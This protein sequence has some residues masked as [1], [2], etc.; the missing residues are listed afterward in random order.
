MTQHD[1]L[2]ELITNPEYLRYYTPFEIRKKLE[3]CGY[4]ILPL[5][6][7]SL[8]GLPFEAGGGYKINFEDGGLFQYHPRQH[9]HH[10]DEYYKI[11]TG[12]GGTHRYDINGTEKSS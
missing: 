6:S 7:G 9:S 1:F 8:K 11:S 10:D 2:H 12:Q 3:A 5:A 4:R